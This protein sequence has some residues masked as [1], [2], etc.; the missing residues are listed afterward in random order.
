MVRHRSSGR[1]LQRQASDF[2]IKEA[3]AR[4][5]RS[6]AAFKLEQIDQRY[7][8]LRPGMRV[9]DLGAAPGSWSQYLI[10]RYPDTRI[11]AV[12]IQTMKDIPNVHFVEMDV[13]DERLYKS[14]QRVLGEKIDLVISDLSPHISG[15][16]TVDTPRMLSLSERVLEIALKTLK[17][18]G[19]LVTK[20]FQ[21]EGF[22]DF[23]TRTRQSFCRCEIFKPQASRRES[24]EVYLFVKGPH[25]CTS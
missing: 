9:L 17:G 25:I 2:Y 15:I 21:G 18:Q 20:V 19:V 13:Y 12:D 1:W 10:L 4:G 23:H 16:K 3:K 11:L 24:R 22:E 14:V 6:R 8:F 5:L 7:H